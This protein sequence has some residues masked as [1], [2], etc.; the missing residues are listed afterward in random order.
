MHLDQMNLVLANDNKTA[1]ELLNLSPH[2]NSLN[3][4]KM[5]S[6]SKASSIP[7][8]VASTISNWLSSERDRPVPAEKLAFLQSLSE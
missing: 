6:L 1:R 2:K 7:K 5:M 4:N 8:P 3:L